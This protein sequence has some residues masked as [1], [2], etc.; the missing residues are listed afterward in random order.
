MQ[1][2]LVGSVTLRTL[3]LGNPDAIVSDIMDE[4]VITVS[5]LDDQETVARQFQK[6]DFMAMPVVDSENRLVG[7]I[8]VDDILEI[9]EEEATEDM[10]RWQLFYHLTSHILERE[11]LRHL[12]QEFHGFLF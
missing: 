3:L 1:R 5:T 8:T 9:I 12:N 4:N 10:E 2:H 11:Y 7:I 6:Y